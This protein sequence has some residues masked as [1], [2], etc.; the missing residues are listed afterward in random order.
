MMGNF[1]MW[2][3]IFMFK[4]LLELLF[5]VVRFVV[6]VILGNVDMIG[7]LLVF[8]SWVVDKLIMLLV[9]VVLIFVLGGL[10]GILWV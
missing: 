6:L 7:G 8:F 9:K 5:N 1:V 10:L 4:G 3:L 2:S